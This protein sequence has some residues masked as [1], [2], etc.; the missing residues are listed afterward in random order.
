MS[1]DLVPE[2]NTTPADTPTSTVT[3][4]P[5]NSETLSGADGP[6]VVTTAVLASK[7]TIEAVVPEA[8]PQSMLNPV[9]ASAAPR[10]MH[11]TTPIMGRER[12]SDRIRLA[13]ALTGLGL[14]VWL[15]R[16]GADTS[17]TLE[18][19][20]GAEYNPARRSLLIL[21]PMILQ[22]SG[23][24]RPHE[25]EQVAAWASANAELIQDY[26]DGSTTSV[27]N[28]TGRVRPVS[29]TSW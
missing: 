13:P 4:P 27:S 2:P 20:P 18:V 8:G 12:G 28:I 24:L 1:T 17:A 23:S 7:A 25:L 9:H 16:G 3:A 22:V 15:R 19:T 11:G 29:T 10:I 5:L 26:W 21:E 6:A 14:S